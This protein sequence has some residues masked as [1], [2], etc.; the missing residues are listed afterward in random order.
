VT[1]A[2]PPVSPEEPETF[3]GLFERYHVKVLLYAERRLP[4]RAAAEDL[5]ADVFYAAW[6]RWSTH[7]PVQLPWLYRV[8]ANKIVDKYRT[9]GRREAMEHALARVEEEN[10]QHEDP[11]ETLALREAI[12]QLDARDRE[13]ITLFYWEGLSAP[14]IGEVLGCTRTTAWA[15]L[16]R[17]RKRLR[18]ALA[19]ETSPAPELMKGAAR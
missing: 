4:S 1:D 19:D 8:A 13:A 17:A 5:A 3:E 16:S 18:K 11:L 10:Q 6:E 2:S 7:G 15:I 14:E 12:L 9:V